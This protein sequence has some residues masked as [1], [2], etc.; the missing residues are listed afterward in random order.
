MF[1]LIIIPQLIGLHIY[2]ET[3][4]NNVRHESVPFESAT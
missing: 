2:A 1:E 3:E 4:K